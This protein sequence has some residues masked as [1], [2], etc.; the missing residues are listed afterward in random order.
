M[1]AGEGGLMKQNKV[2]DNVFYNINVDELKFVMNNAVL[3]FVGQN[4]PKQLPLDEYCYFMNLYVVDASLK[5][6][7][8]KHGEFAKNKAVQNEYIKD[9]LKELRDIYFVPMN[10]A[11]NSQ[12]NKGSLKVRYSDRES[13]ISPL[14][15]LNKFHVFLTYH[16]A[17][18]LGFT[19]N[20]VEAQRNDGYRKVENVIELMQAAEYGANLV[21]DFRLDPLESTPSK[22]CY[23]M[24]NSTE[25]ELYNRICV[26]IENSQ[27]DQPSK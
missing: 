7:L 11:F 24:V 5:N 10:K 3:G 2:V 20:T 23:F 6:Y 21:P 16:Y 12:D 14:L 19:Y 22:P 9:V 15:D 8:S 26:C 1:L 18:L 13:F 4:H 17:G 27:N 25:K